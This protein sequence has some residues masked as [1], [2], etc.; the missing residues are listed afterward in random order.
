[1][2][3]LD[4][5]MEMAVDERQGTNIQL[6][7]CP[8]C[9]VTIRRNLRYGTI[10]NQLLADI[11]QV[12]KRVVGEVADYGP[13]SRTLIRQLKALRLPDETK[14]VYTDRLRSVG[15]SATEVACIENIVNFLEHVSLWEREVQEKARSVDG[16][17]RENLRKLQDDMKKIK[18][19]LNVPR[20]RLSE[21]QV[22]ECSMEITRF[23]LLSSYH[24]LHGRIKTSDHEL[25]TDEKK[26]RF[27]VMLRQLSC[28]SPLNPDKEKSAREI[29]KETL[30]CMSGL[31]ITEQERVQIVEAMGMK[32]GHWFKCPNGRTMFV[33]LSESYCFAGIAVAAGINALE[34][35]LLCLY[36]RHICPV[37]TPYVRLFFLSVFLF[38]TLTEICAQFSAWKQCTEW[39]QFAVEYFF[40]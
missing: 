26:Q 21:Q 29:L 24:Q 15:L 1:M 27:V 34:N 20:T 9:R 38:R 14:S 36:W 17:T 6:K 22:R 39:S 33:L 40:L 23:D 5:W 28:G 37:D 11:E 19:W 4:R 7:Q 35:S 8:R 32:Q 31:G 25:L 10:I 13:R 3:G 18:E 2:S 30:K 16:H 12:K